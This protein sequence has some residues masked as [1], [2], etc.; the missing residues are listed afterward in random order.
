[1]YK[2]GWKGVT[3][4]SRGGK[5]KTTQ[6]LSTWFLHIPIPFM[7]LQPAHHLVMC[8]FSLFCMAVG[9]ECFA[10]MPTFICIRIFVRFIFR[11]EDTLLFREFPIIFDDFS[12]Y[13]YDIGIS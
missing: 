4:K 7:Q 5:S 9:S 11:E 3:K 12:I 8:N 13:V 1:M 2:E 10:K 6:I